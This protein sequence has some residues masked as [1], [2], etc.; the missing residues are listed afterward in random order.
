MPL[1][2]TGPVVCWNRTISSAAPPAGRRVPST[3]APTSAASPRSLGGRRRPAA[4]AA[5]RTADTDA[6]DGGSP[7]FTYARYTPEQAL[8]SVNTDG[9][10][11]GLGF[12]QAA[13]ITAAS[14]VKPA[15]S[16]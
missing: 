3:A 14:L 1:A 11:A 4:S 8:T 10:A 15:R 9:A 16:D 2:C 7:G 13:G 12:V 6:G 5:S